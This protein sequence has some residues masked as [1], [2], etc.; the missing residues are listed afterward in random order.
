SFKIFSDETVAR[1]TSF[2]SINMESFRKKPVALFIQ[3]SVAEQRYFSVLTSLFFE[4][5]FSYLM[6]GFPSEKDQDVFLLIDESSSL[7][8]PTLP[9]AVANVRKHRAGIMLLA[10][11]FAQIVHHYGRYDA[12][13]IKSNCFAQM[14][15]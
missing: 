12:D 5:F 10:Q 13:A 1:V 6:S 15:F 11:D 14:Y 2:D 8:L 9:L 4:Q 7:N 3:N